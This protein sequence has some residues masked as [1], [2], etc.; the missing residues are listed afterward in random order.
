MPLADTNHTNEAE[1]KMSVIQSGDP[2]HF[3]SHIEKL[4]P[5]TPAGFRIASIATDTGVFPIYVAFEGEL[6][7]TGAAI[8]TPAA[9]GALASYYPMNGDRVILMRTGRTWTI[10]GGIIQASEF[11]SGAIVARYSNP[12]TVFT[13]AATWTPFSGMTNAYIDTAGRITASAG[14]G[15]LVPSA[16]MYHVRARAV[17]ANTAAPRGVG[18]CINSGIPGIMETSLHSLTA[19]SVAQQV[20]SADMTYPCVAGDILNGT[21]F[22]AN[23]GANSFVAG[24]FDLLVT[25][26]K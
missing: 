6:D 26:V 10:L 18:A 14:G 17:F 11:F 24:S 4:I 9:V 8:T 2:H 3:L 7:D 15:F 19:P 12:S 20:H 22:Q 13:S 21:T 23:S 5:K 25:K 16:G 1:I